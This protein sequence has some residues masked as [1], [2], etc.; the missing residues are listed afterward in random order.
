[1]TLETYEGRGAKRF[2]LLPRLI[3]D[4]RGLVTIWNDQG[5]SI[6]FWRSVF[7]R[8]APD[9]IE[10]IGQLANTRVGQGNTIREFSEQLLEALNEA[11]EQAATAQ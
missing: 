1:M 7:E 4:R 2:T 10:W 11:Y 8:K 3:V 9:S 6:Q 5:A